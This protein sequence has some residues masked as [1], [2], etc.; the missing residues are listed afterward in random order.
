MATLYTFSVQV[1]E[2]AAALGGG[3]YGTPHIIEST[4][5]LTAAQKLVSD[6]SQGNS[7]IT[8]LAAQTISYDLGLDTAGF[9]NATMSVVMND[10]PASSNTGEA[11]TVANQLMP[12]FGIVAQTYP[13]DGDVL[14]FFP[15]CKITGDWTWKLE[16][17][18]IVVPQF[19]C[20]AIEDLTLGYIMKKFDRPAGGT[21]TFPPQI[22]A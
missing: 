2:V 18:K 19:K 16:F 21:I 13:D 12:Y 7:K 17:G 4:K 5:I 15:R 11:W 14:I 3:L 8:S 22:L 1:V 6:R 10:A 9:D 20:E